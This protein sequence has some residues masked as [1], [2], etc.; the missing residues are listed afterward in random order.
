MWGG[1]NVA[2]KTILEDIDALSAAGLRSLIAGL[3]VAPLLL[4]VEE[5]ERGQKGWWRSLFR[6]SALFALAL[7]VQQIAYL[8]SS[9]TNASFLVNT[10]VVI[11]PLFAWLLMSA[12]PLPSTY[13]AVGMTFAGLC[14]MSDGG[15]AGIGKGDFTALLSAV[16]YALWLVELE[17][18]MRQFGRPIATSV[19]QFLGTAVVALPL[20]ALNG[21]VTLPGL[22]GAAPELVVLGVFST[23][24][25]FGLIT[26]AQRFTTATH[27][28]IIVGAE[29]IFGALAAFLLLGERPSTAALAGGAMIAAAIV[30]VALSGRS[31]EPAVVPAQS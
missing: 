25:G 29:C 27:A 17:R 11:T 19:V 14:L 9:V 31:T 22:Y 23:A 18:H 28:A 26:L 21:G 12:R 30:V 4:F 7:V 24:L 3:L 2:Q 16:I 6:V 8:D 15:V 1:G 20:G 5:G 13:L 10:D